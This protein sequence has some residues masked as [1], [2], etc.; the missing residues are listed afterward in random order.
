MCGCKASIIIYLLT[1]SVDNI[2]AE[3]LERF[4]G[5]KGDL[6]GLCRF[7]YQQRLCQY[8]RELQRHIGDGP[9]ELDEAESRRQAFLLTRHYIGRLGSHLKAARILAKAGWTMPNL[10]DN[11]TIQTRPSPTPPLLPPPTDRLTTLNGI[12][13]RML[14]RDSKKL[15]QYQ[16]A[17][18]TMDAK[19][20]IQDRLKAQFKAKDFMP[21]VHAELILL[22]YF[23]MKRLPFVD[24][25]R[26]IGCSKPACYCCYHY[27]SLHPGGFVR[28]ASHGVRYLSWR[29]PD[30]GEEEDDTL[31]E[32]H[33]RDILNNVIKQIRLDAFRQIEKRRGPSAWHPDST[34]GITR[35]QKHI[36]LGGGASDSELPSDDEAPSGDESSLSSVTSSGHKLSLGDSRSSN[37]D[38]ISSGSEH[39][40]DTIINTRKF[41]DTYHAPVPLT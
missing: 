28:P 31:D 34:T 3:W 36:T 19:F 22:E 41:H 2:L 25:D 1:C 18:A 8:V 32:N 11:F 37:G 9:Q 24:D 27:I 40:L 12:I 38:A 10:F 6:P 29:P 4:Q 17:L 23:H 26:F 13:T 21:R 30:L 7:S 5:F 33:Q 35:S 16:K 14:P 39:T 15:Q 20:N